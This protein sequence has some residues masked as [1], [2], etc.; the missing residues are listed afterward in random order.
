MTAKRIARAILAVAVVS[1]AVVVAVLLYRRSTPVDFAKHAEA[2]DATRRLQSESADLQQQVLSVRFGL[3]RQYDSLTS[4]LAHLD[5]LAGEIDEKTTAVLGPGTVTSELTALRAALQGR[6]ERVERFKS[7][8]AILRNSLYY[9]P[10]AG[11]N[12][13]TGLRE[14]GADPDGAVA[15]EI[16]GIIGAALVYNLLGGRATRA[17]LVSRIERTRARLDG[18]PEGLR[19][20]FELFLRHTD[21][22]SRQ[23]DV[24]DGLLREIRNE[25]VERALERLSAVY[26]AE[27]SARMAASNQFRLGLYGWSVL[28]MLLVA[29]VEWKLRQLYVSLERRVAERTRDLNRALDELWGEMKLARKIQTALLPASPVLE[30]FEVAATMQPA[31]EVGGDYYDVFRAGEQDW[32]LIGDVSGHGVPSGLVMMMCQTAM[33]T[34]AAA[35]PDLSPDALLALVNG[36]LT[37]NIERLGEKRYMTCTAISRTQEGHLRFAG[38]HQDLLI[39]RAATG[40]VERPEAE[41]MWLG[42]RPNITGMQATREVDLQ[43]GDALL[44]YTD[45]LTEATK[46]GEMLDVVALERALREH[47]H[48][49]A[50]QILAKVLDTVSSAEVHDDVAVVVLKR[51]VQVSLLEAAE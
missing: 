2:V 51:S 30:G 19:G 33:R 34:A 49:S 21:I 18:M 39:Y 4:S 20:D 12:L 11:A 38:M 7:E 1:L 36:P 26:E 31:D 9:L 14:Q 29:F 48:S 46:D 13:V 5:A 47:G 37:E 35:R 8:A 45:G 25:D 24:V 50:Q 22:I 43:Q 27:V 44:L 40:E 3:L 42:L 23:L 32:V 28:M 15:G 17:D 16:N 6:H 10:V 41:G